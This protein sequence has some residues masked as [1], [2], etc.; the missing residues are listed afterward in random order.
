MVWR[1]FLIP[2]PLSATGPKCSLQLPEYQ[3]Q[4]WAASTSL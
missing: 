3:T 4:H 2:V 1:N